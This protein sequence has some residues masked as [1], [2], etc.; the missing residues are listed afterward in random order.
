MTEKE[1]AARQSPS[2]PPPSRPDIRGRASVPGGERESAA[3]RL[4][5]LVVGKPRDPMDP[6][7]FHHV[8]LM[9]FLAWVGLGADGLSSS[10]YGPEEAFKALGQHMYLA[11]FLCVMMAATVFIISFAY[12]LLIEHFPGGGGGY[13]VATKLLGPRFGVVSG[14]ALIVDYVLTITVSVATGCDAVFS[15]LPRAWGSHELTTE[16][17]V[18]CLLVV[19]N[20]RGVKESVKFLLPIFLVFVATH[21]VLISYGLI[22]HFSALPSVL[23]GA[24]TEA[25]TSSSAIGLVPTL[26]ILLRAYSLGGGT[27]TG[28]EAVSNGVQILREP[29]VR[30]AK[31]TMLYMALSLAFTAGGI[32]FCYLLIHAHSAPGKT[33]NAV[34]AERLFGPWK[35]GGFDLGGALVVVTLVSEGALLFV[36]AQTGFIDGPRILANMAVDSWVPRRFAQLSDRLVTKNGVFLMGAG[37]VAVLLYSKGKSDLLILMYSINVFLTFTLT[38][39]GMS[40]FWITTRKNPAHRNWWRNLAIHGTGLAMCLFILI[41]SIVAK[42]TEGGWLTV[43][44]TSAFILLA[45]AVRRHYERVGEQLRRLDDVLL[46][47][48]VRPHEVPEGPVDPTQPVAAVLVNGFSG[49]G[50]HTFLTIQQIF[51]GQFKHYLFV[52]VGVIDSASF[53]GADEVEALQ[54]S[55][56]EDLAKYMQFARRFGFRAEAREAIATEV[57][58]TLADLAQATRA[59]YPRCVFFLGAL[60]FEKDNLVHRILH[61]ETAL[62]IQRRLQFAGIETVVLPVRVRR[63][64][65]SAA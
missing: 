22:D 2:G 52:S 21:V 32:L 64:V 20:L 37:A 51:P 44:V 41:V 23:R 11:V 56:R 6:Q 59:E 4:R 40:R 65:G 30:N 45:F 26:F 55:T 46:H 3:R 49:V 50:V 25:R 33:L 53:K 57:V 15:F 18:L 31:R 42:F 17:L 27:Y 62:A 9:A 38:E 48:P 54:Q 13:L 5:N 8:S 16:V 47:I 63:P 43:V 58:E 10:A 7:V 60:V 39:L 14:C 61:N 29:R 24:V 28:I 36:A 19:L 12:S 35:L 34:L 1:S